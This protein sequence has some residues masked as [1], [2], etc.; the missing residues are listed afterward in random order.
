M[1]R[2]HQPK[3]KEVRRDWHIIDAKE[4]VL[5]RLSTEI[6]GF[7]VGKHKR[8]YVPHLDCGDYVVVVN[9][10]KVKL[11]GKKE[12]KKFYFRH[13]GY[14]GGAKTIPVSRVRREKPT[15][16]IRLSVLGMLP[17][18]RLRDDRVQ[19]L[20]LFVGLKHPYQE[21]FSKEKS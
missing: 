3:G 2:T 5:G 13:S 7:L 18:N 9:S 19:R 4:K 15:E 8:D 6:A 20:K 11:T 1:F 10:E 21:K 14:P 17:K 16:I 12:E